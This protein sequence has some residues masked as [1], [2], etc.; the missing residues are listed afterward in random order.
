MSI[1]H[2]S[3]A[4]RFGLALSG[5]GYRA[6]AFH[7]G[8]LKKL[9]ELGLLQKVDVLSTISGGSITGAAYC[10]HQGSYATFHA[11]MAKALQECSVIGYV[12]RSAAF[13]RFA[14]LLLTFL[15]LS[16]GLL[17]TRW[18]PFSKLEL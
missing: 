2:P 6:A 5:G 4:S 11:V 10:L 7:L 9:D 17:F 14:L 1:L 15:F 18:A 3:V 12:L 13:V 16:I 8:T